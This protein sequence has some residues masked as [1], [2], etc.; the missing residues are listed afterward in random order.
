M[1]QLQTHFDNCAHYEPR[2]GSRE[3]A[4]DYCRK[5]ESR[6]EEPIEWGEW[7]TNPGQRTDLEAACELV[8]GGA[9]DSIVARAMP[10]TF[11]LFNRGLSVYRRTIT[12][13][14]ESDT[15]F[16]VECHYGSPGKL[17]QKTMANVLQHTL[18]T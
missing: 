15:T 4:R 3:Q 13:N 14:R 9:P 6:L 16:E 2:H 10:K 17:E 5:L 18:Q 12:P 7:T 8:K 1:S 11:V